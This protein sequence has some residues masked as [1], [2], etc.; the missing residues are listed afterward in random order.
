MFEINDD[1]VESSKN[2]ENKIL[3]LKELLDKIQ[4]SILQKTNLANRLLTASTVIKG[5]SIGTGLAAASLYALMP[6]TFGATSVP[7]AA[8]SLATGIL[9]SIASAL[10]MAY[11]DVLKT[12]ESFKEIEDI[13]SK[14]SF[15][16]VNEMASKTTSFSLS[17]FK[18]KYNIMKFD[19]L[20][21]P[22]SLSRVSAFIGPLISTKKL[23]EDINELEEFKKINNEIK[24]GSLE[25]LKTISRLETIRWTVINETI[26]D[27]PYTQ[28]GVGG[29]NTHF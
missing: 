16:T 9:G 7:A 2:V 14:Y 26:I 4:K 23:L 1:G 18:L 11:Y 27:K 5:I 15:M 21:N 17:L 24:E 6:F 25:L 19:S 10:K 3:N 22:N 28:G 20:I 13:L 8:L 29:A 12:I